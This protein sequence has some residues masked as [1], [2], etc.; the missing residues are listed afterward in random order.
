MPSVDWYGAQAFWWQHVVEHN[1]L[2]RWA[3]TIATHGAWMPYPARD[4]DG[5]DW[6]PEFLALRNCNL[7]MLHLCSA[8]YRN[9]LRRY[10]Q[11]SFDTDDEDMA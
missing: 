10:H 6:K 7:A 3:L 8:R 9:V 1:Y 5:R 2:G 11:H 4:E